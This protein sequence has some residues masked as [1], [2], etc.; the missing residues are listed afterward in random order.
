MSSILRPAL[1]VERHVADAAGLGLGEIVAAGV[2]AIG[3]RLPRRLAIDGDVAL[4]H[5]QEPLAVGRV[6]RFDH[7]V[8]DQAAPAGGQVELVAVVD[9][10]AAFDDDVGMRLE[11]ADQLVAGRHRLA[12][13][14]PPLG[15]GDDPL[16][17]RPIVADL[18]LPELDGRV[19]RAVASRLAA[20]AR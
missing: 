7:Q 6:A 18:G 12:G 3:G 2:A 9:V 11:Q 13:Q 15:L 8:E 16:D 17:Q 20:S 4:Q 5:R 14:H 1:L 10:A 19:G